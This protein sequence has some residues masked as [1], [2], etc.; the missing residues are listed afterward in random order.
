MPG[1]LGQAIG[2][3]VSGGVV[4]VRRGVT[5]HGWTRK[6]EANSAGAA[7]AWGTKVTFAQRRLQASLQSL[8][9]AS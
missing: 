5:I 2:G 6:G 9:P 4:R 7:A 8:T 3:G 1:R